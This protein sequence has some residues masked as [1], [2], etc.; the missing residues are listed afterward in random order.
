M[1]RLKHF[2]CLIYMAFK[3]TYLW[4]GSNSICLI[5]TTSVPNSLEILSRYFDSVLVER[6]GCGSGPASTPSCNSRILGGGAE[7]TVIIMIPIMHIHQHHNDPDHIQVCSCDTPRCNLATETL[8][9]WTKRPR[10]G[11]LGLWLNIFFWKI[12][13]PSQSVYILFQQQI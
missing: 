9:K 1:W 5:C 4:K 13:I 2:L 7:A 11:L 10:G 8:W 12:N 3:A 6:R